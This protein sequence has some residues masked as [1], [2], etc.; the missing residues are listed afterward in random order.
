MSGRR[1]RCM[2]A[3]RP[4]L[5]ALGN[6]SLAEAKAKTRTRPRSGLQKQVLGLYRRYCR[7]IAAKDLPAAQKL[8]IAEHV[9]AQVL[10]GRRSRNQCST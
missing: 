6:A 8:Q 1:A 9:R 2:Q 10:G 7:A 3:A 4:L 5:N